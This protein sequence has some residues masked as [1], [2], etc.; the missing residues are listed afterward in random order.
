MNVTIPSF[1][2]RNRIAL[3]LGAGLLLTGGSTVALSARPAAPVHAGTLPASDVGHGVSGQLLGLRPDL[4]DVPSVHLHAPVT[5]VGRRLDGSVDVPSPYS[6]AGWWEGGTGIGPSGPVV[7]VGHVDDRKGPA[8]FYHLKDIQPGAAITLGTSHGKPAHY[9]VDAVRQYPDK[10]FPTEL[11]YGST[12]RPT[13][14]LL[15]CG[16]YSYRTR[17]YVD[18]VVVFAHLI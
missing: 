4:V 11:I 14:R 16:G 17:H 3:L 5:A 10:Q 6:T 7:L 18:N 13:L 2:V 1:A 8:V 12:A 9:L 15:T